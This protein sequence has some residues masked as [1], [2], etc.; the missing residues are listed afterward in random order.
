M[1]IKKKLHNFSKFLK[2]VINDL[3]KLRFQ[4]YCASLIQ[5]VIKKNIFASTTSWCEG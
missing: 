5:A 3:Y 1:V 4:N 2:N